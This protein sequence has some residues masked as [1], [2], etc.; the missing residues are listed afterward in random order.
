MLV[1]CTHRINTFVDC[2]L[3]LSIKDKVT[4]FSLT[5][6]NTVRVRRH[7]SDNNI[8]YIQNWKIQL[9]IRKVAKIAV[10]MYLCIPM[11]VYSHTVEPW[12]VKTL[13]MLPYPRFHCSVYFDMRN[14]MHMLN[15]ENLAAIYS[16]NIT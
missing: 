8:S 4:R 9:L 6:H 3:L 13:K 2:W 1:I 7:L 16:I 5:L 11:Q 15:Y 10:F 12:N 14:V